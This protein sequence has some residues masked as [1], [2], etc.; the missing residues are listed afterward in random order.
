MKRFLLKLLFIAIITISA[1]RLLA[2]AAAHFYRTATTTD[3]YKL[4][5]VTYHMLA[6]LIFMGSSRCHHHYVPAIIADSLKTDVYNAGLW[7]MR[8]IYFQYSLL[9]NILEHYT[10]KTIVLEIHPIDYLQTPFSDLETM[11]ALAPFIH[12]SAGCD[13]TLKKAGFYYKNLFSHLYRY[14]SQ[15]ANLLFGNISLRTDPA[16]AGFKPLSGTLDTT[17]RKIEPEKFPFAPDQEKIKYLQAFIEKCQEKGIK[18]L[19]IY[20][21][22]YA[23]EKNS[24]L[25]D[26]PADLALKNNVPFINHYY[27]EGITNHREYYFDYGHLNTEGAKKYSSIVASE[28]RKYVE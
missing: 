12:H 23:V 20:S 10:P 9:S 4:N 14:N 27:L 7:G 13:K 1:D 21:P 8:N 25:F 11:G 5:Q 16:D 17:Q 19:F 24:R 15:F 3:E 26:I 18:L 2:L 22:M 28:L 6:P